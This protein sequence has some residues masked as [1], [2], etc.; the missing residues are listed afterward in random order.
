MLRRDEWIL[1]VLILLCGCGGGWDRSVGTATMG[2]NQAALSGG[3]YSDGGVT[4]PE[5]PAS[6]VAKRATIIPEEQRRMIVRTGEATIEVDSFPAAAESVA[7]IVDQLGGYASGFEEHADAAGRRY[8]S[9]TIRVPAAEWKILIARLRSLGRVVSQSDH[10]EDVTEE[11]CDVEGRLDAQRK[12]E[13]ELLALMNA[14]RYGN[15]GQLLE[16]E[17]EVARVRGEIESMEGRL[18]YLSNQSALSTL[19]LSL[20]E[21]SAIADGAVGALDPVRDALRQSLVLFASSLATLI[22]LSAIAAPWVGTALVL[23]VLVR[24]GRFAVRAWRGR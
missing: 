6:A 2:Q 1:A 11:Y 5:R 21:P 14:S 7:V 13:K 3:I 10:A 4:A 9:F 15:L 18:R 8:G 19:T 12:L 20:R 24:V 23:V 17:Q 16:I 22:T